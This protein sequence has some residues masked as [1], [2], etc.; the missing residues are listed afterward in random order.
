MLRFIRWSCVVIASA[1]ALR[2][3]DDYVHSTLGSSTEWSALKWTTDDTVLFGGIPGYSGPDK[4]IVLVRYSYFVSAYDADRLS[5]LWVAHVDEQDSLA[6]DE[7]RKKG[8]WDRGT[9]K[10]KPDENVVTYSNAIGYRFVTDANYVNANPPDLPPGEKGYDKITR[11][12]MASNQEM[13]S[14]GT[15]AE[16]EIS[17]TE[18][19][20]CGKRSR[21]IASSGPESWAEWR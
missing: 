8:H 7:V 20:H 18:S 11:G 16:G 21:S 15:D 13:K 4:H 3:A 5:P 2:A 10:F 9:D 14:L 19:F 6:K 12:H 1:I 17:Q